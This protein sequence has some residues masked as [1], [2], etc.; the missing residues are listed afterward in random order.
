MNNLSVETVADQNKLLFTMQDIVY[1]EMDWDLYVADRVTLFVTALAMISN[2]AV[3]FTLNK[4][5]NVKN[6]CPIRLLQILAIHQTVWGT[7]HGVEDP[8]LRPLDSMV[9][10]IV[11]RIIACKGKI[12]SKHSRVKGPQPLEIH[13]FVKF[14]CNVRL[15]AHI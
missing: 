3:F 7:V 1:V 2:L 6:F 13:L 4:L 15:A 10:S 8:K 9:P 11:P 14:T 12:F 5:P